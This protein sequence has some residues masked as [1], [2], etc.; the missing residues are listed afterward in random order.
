MTQKAE[1]FQ[2]FI[3]PEKIRSLLSR[4]EPTEEE[5]DRIIQKALRLR[6]LSPED[7]A[8]L[9]TSQNP[10]RLNKLLAAAGKIKEAIYGRRIVL[11]APLYI[12]NRCSNDCTYCS[13]RV[14]NTSIA[15]TS[16]NLDEIREET[17]AL[18]AEGHKRILLLAG[19]TSEESVDRFTEAIRTIYSVNHTA[20]RTG[21]ISSIRRINV[22]IAPL[23]TEEFRKLKEAKIGTYACFQETYDPEIYARCHPSGRKSDYL[24]RLSV[25]DR[26]M[27][28]GIDDVG[29]GALF[30]LGDWRFEILGLLEHAR[31][32]EKVF[33]CGPHTVSVPRIEPAE[34]APDALHVPNPVS[35][36]EFRHIV[37]ILRL[38]LP[39]TGII[40]STRETAVLR[41]ELFKYGVSQ[42]SAGSRTNP[43]AYSHKTGTGSQ[44]Q[45][46]DHRSL[47]EVVQ[48]LAHQGYIPSFCTGCYRK[49]RVG[50][51]FMDLA[52]PGL[53][54]R[55]CEPN[56]LFT[57]QE[58]LEDF[59]TEAL[60]QSVA[61]VID[62][63]IQSLPDDATRQKVKLGL[64]KINEGE[65]DVYL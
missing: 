52:K 27:E 37:A 10:A 46:G 31:H 40:L 55:Y 30:G 64:A 2:T 26:A 62:P 8:V 32:L 59:G 35:D 6:G 43:G 23:T 29:I 41:N 39:Y 18:L 25:M 65:R 51:D 1:N 17:K 53:I 42:I 9:L 48:E 56:A 44:F 33:G 21:K 19:E 28:A 63:F 11:F 50:A 14:S 16:L 3:I 60:I 54:K 4:P 15:R 22:E 12:G 58:Y 57:F 20:S 36:D 5:F 38:A 7:A 47:A 13:F 45:L 49:G 24:W 34:G 61:K